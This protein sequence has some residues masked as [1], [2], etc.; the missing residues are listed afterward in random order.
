MTATEPQHHASQPGIPPALRA[1]ITPE[2]DE[3]P[4]KPEKDPPPHEQP[5][6]EQAPIEEPTPPAP[7][8][9]T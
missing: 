5:L 7:P 6:P 4:P 9:K 1:H 8:I 3:P 2:P